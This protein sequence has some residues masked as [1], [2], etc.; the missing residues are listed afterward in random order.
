M[1]NIAIAPPYKDGQSFISWTA[2]VVDVMGSLPFGTW[3]GQRGKIETDCSFAQ[4]WKQAGGIAKRLKAEGLKKGDVVI[5]CVLSY[6]QKTK[7][8]A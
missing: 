7:P 1:A 2:D 3:Y 5:T 4:I 6:P 8:V